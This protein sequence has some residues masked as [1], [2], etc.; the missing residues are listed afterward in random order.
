MDWTNAHTSRD[1]V[2]FYVFS[3]VHKFRRTLNEV[4]IFSVTLTYFR[5]SQ[6]R[7]IE[8]YI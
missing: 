8:A 4:H 3:R 5:F 1:L 6:V 2:L 7:E